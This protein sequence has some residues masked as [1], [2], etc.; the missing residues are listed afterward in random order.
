[1]AVKILVILVLVAMVLHLI[2]PFGLPGLRQRKDA[3]K[4]ALILIAAM[5]M[6][7]VFRPA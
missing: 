4:I 1:M 2:K 3:W 6:A 7:L 5:M